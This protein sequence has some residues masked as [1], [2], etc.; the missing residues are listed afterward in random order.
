MFIIIDICI[1]II[2]VEVKNIELIYEY[3]MYYEDNY[4]SFG[5]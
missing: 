1:V 4:D 3:E 2:D 5:W